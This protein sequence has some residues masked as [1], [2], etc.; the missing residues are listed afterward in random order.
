[1]DYPQVAKKLKQSAALGWK[2]GLDSIRRLCARLGNPQDAV[3][4]VHVA[5]TNGKGSVCAMTASVLEAAGYRTGLYTSPYLTDWR[6]SFAINGMMITPEAFAR[7]LT[8]VFAQADALAA[9]GLYLTEFELLTAGAFLWF[10][11]SGCDAAVIETGMGGRLDA[12]NVV[13]RPLVSVITAVSYDHMA[14]LGDTPAQIA[15]EKCGIDKPGG[16]TVCYPVQPEEAMRVILEAARHARNQLIVPDTARLSVSASG[17]GGTS[18]AYRGVE[19]RVRMGGAHQAFNAATAIETAF[20]LRTQGFA[21]SGEAIRRGLGEAYLPARQEV[22]RERPLVLLDGAH[23]IQGIQAL[24]EAVRGISNR[25]M[26]VVMGM[27]SDKPYPEAAAVMAALCGRFCAVR[28]NNPRA[29]AP[30]ELKDIAARQGVAAQTYE[31]M[32]EA[33]K[34]D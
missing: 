28:P 29:L 26:A 22:L 33:V 15:R 23:N 13:A 8:Q 34:E 18:F 17:I 31:S 1:M 2:P 10:A 12:T 11:Q 3:P 27:L 32:D 7:V 6:D 9:E 25:P 5:G 14:Y 21:I 30:R 20:V 16:A 4:A 24:A 19:A